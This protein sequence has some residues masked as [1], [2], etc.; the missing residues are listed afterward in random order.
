[1]GSRGGGLDPDFL[2]DL[3]LFPHPGEQRASDLGK[4]GGSAEGG[5]G[6]PCAGL[7]SCRAPTLTELPGPI[8]NPLFVFWESSE[9]QGLT[10]VGL[11]RAGACPPSCFRSQSQ[12]QGGE[13]PCRPPPS[14]RLSDLPI[15]V[16]AMPVPPQRSSTPSFFSP[17]FPLCQ[18]QPPKSGRG[19]PGKLS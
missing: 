18:H 5:S 17:S 1:M 10:Q 6:E 4:G 14:V 16:G 2:P 13:R 11:V 3:D 9:N 7:N 19:R 15:R 12:A 8:R